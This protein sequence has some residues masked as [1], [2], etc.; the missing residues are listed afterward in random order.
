MCFFSVARAR[1][2]ARQ[3]KPEQNKRFCSAFA[4]F[5]LAICSPHSLVWDCWHVR[6][7]AVVAHTAIYATPLRSISSWL[8]ETATETTVYSFRHTHTRSQSIVHDGSVPA[9]RCWNRFTAQRNANAYGVY[10]SRYLCVYTYVAYAECGEYRAARIWSCLFFSPRILLLFF[11]L[12]V[13][14]LC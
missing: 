7:I 1:S 13:C 10:S 9:H 11:G 14:T 4:R 6:S 5:W 8:C 12:A 3:P 2:I